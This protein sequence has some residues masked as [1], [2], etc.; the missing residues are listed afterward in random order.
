[1]S[2]NSLSR[3]GDSFL[4]TGTLQFGPLSADHSFTSVQSR[5]HSEPSQ[6]PFQANLHSR[7][8]TG[9]ESGIIEEF[10]YQEQHPE[11]YSVGRHSSL[12]NYDSTHFFQF[13]RSQSVQSFRG[14]LDQETDGMRKFE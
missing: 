6:R 5:V 8:T 10:T 11:Q 12:E 4:S 13:P 2:A 14:R 3:K 1:M 7:N 9:I